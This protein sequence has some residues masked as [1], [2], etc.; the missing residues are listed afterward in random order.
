ME[1]WDICS[2]NVWLMARPRIMRSASSIQS[3]GPNSR[4]WLLSFSQTMA[5]H[6]ICGISGAASG[7]VS[8]TSLH[9]SINLSSSSRPSLLASRWITSRLKLMMCPSNNFSIR[10][11]VAFILSLCAAATAS[12]APRILT[13]DW[14][15]RRGGSSSTVTPARLAICFSL[16][17]CIHKALKTR[18]ETTAEKLTSAST[19]SGMRPDS[20]GNR[21]PWNCSTALATSVGDCILITACPFPVS[22]SPACTCTSDIFTP[23]GSSISFRITRRSFSR[24]TFRGYVTITLQVWTKV[25]ARGFWIMGRRMAQGPLG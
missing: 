10:A 22:L 12:P 11:R 9:S 13:I 23:I 16:Y 6:L 24:L 8:T 25:E 4:T 18:P 15:P 3:L 2:E 5:R 17:S 1:K 14:C 21:R 7:G 20:F 19:V